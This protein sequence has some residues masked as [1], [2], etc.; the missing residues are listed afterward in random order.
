[1]RRVIERT[2]LPS[3]LG[4]WSSSIDRSSD[5]NPLENVLGI[6]LQRL[7][8]QR[9]QQNTLTELRE[10]INQ[11]WEQLPGLVDGY[12]KDCWE[13]ENSEKHKTMQQKTENYS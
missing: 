9:K 1:M 10:V 8:E 4:K 7:R 3:G 6:P 2:L 13:N 12:M 5:F 11:E